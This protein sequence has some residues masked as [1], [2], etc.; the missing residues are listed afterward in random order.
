[1]VQRVAV[2]VVLADVVADHVVAAE[3]LELARLDGVG[4]HC[5]AGQPVPGDV[6]AL[7]QVVIGGGFRGAISA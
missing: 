5:H 3:V 1:V 4:M 2:E 6:I 7:D